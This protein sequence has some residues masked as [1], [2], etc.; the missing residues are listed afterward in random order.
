MTKPRLSLFASTLLFVISIAQVNASRA[1]ATT[2][3]G[4]R[5]IRVR[6]GQ[7][8]PKPTPTPTSKSMPTPKSKP[9]PLRLV[10]QQGQPRLSNG[11]TL[12]SPDGRLVA[13]GDGGTGDV[14]LW[15]V[16]T[17]RE[18]RRLTDNKG[19]PGAQDIDGWLWGAFSSDGHLLVTSVGPNV[20]LWNLLTG[21]RL[22]LATHGDNAFFEP[23]DGN[24]PPVAFNAQGSQIVVNG[25]EYKLT[26][27]ARTGR[28]LSRTSLGRAAKKLESFDLR[29]PRNA[30]SPGGRFVASAKDGVVTV[31]EKATRREVGSVRFVVMGPGYTSSY[32]GQ[33]WHDEL[34]ALAVSP[35]GRALVTADR[36]DLD[37]PEDP[38]NSDHVIRLWDVKTG[39]QTHLLTGMDSVPPN[40]RFTAAGGLLGVS[41]KKHEFYNAREMLSG[42]E[43]RW[44]AA[45]DTTAREEVSP[46]GRF[47]VTGAGLVG[48]VWDAQTGERLAR[49]ESKLYP[50]EKADTVGWSVARFTP[51]DTVTFFRDSAYGEPEAVTLSTLDWKETKLAFELPL[52]DDERGFVMS[53]DGRA[54][55]WETVGGGEDGSQAAQRVNVWREGRPVRSFKVDADEAYTDASHLLLSPDGRR[56]LVATSNNGGNLKQMLVKVYDVDS[57]RAV[58]TLKRPGFRVAYFAWSPDGR[59]I[60][61]SA[62]TGAG[63][64]AALWDAAT[65]AELRRLDGPEDLIEEFSPDSRLL[66]TFGGDGFERV[67]EASTGKELCRFITRA[68][69][70]WVAVDPEG[71]FDAS[72]LEEI[73]GVHWLAPE[74]PLRPLP[75]EIFM[76]DYYE[77]RLLA[78]ILSGERFAPVRSLSAVK[79]AQPSVNIISVEQDKGRPEFARVTVE[80]SRPADGSEVYDLR[81][82]REG[83]LVAYAPTAGGVLKTDA[84]T[85]K[86][87]VTFDDIRLP[88]AGVAEV[89]DEARAD[90]DSDASA[91]AG[92]VEFSAYAFNE[93]RVKSLTARTSFVPPA[94]TPQASKGRAYVISVGV[95]AYENEE[96]DLRFAANDARRLQEVVAARVRGGGEYEEVVSVP[97]ISDYASEGGRKQTPRVF[98]ET[99]ATKRNFRAVLD[100]LAGRKVDE[101]VLKGIP[102]ADRLRRATP[103]DLIIVS[104]SSHGYADERGRFFLF[105][106]DVGKSG[107]LRD[108]LGRAISSDELG[109]WL[110]DVDAGELILVVDACHSAASVQGEGFKPGPMGSRGLGQLSYDKGMRIL[111]STQASDVALESGLIEQ[112]LLTYALTRDGLEA[113][114]ADFRPKDARIT[115][116]EWL[117]YGVERVP[118]LHAEVEQ[119]LAEMKA[120]ADA[121]AASNLSGDE[122]ARVV[123]FPE[124]ERGLKVKVSGQSTRTQQPALFDFARRRRDAVLSKTQ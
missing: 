50:G 1:S 34:Y 83:R 84:Q 99:A 114:R 93:D 58:Y 85:G 16:E 24:H 106:S 100:L 77:P 119:K 80:A 62:G 38:S 76:R 82:F 12:F 63:E 20:R 4:A 23:D 53:P 68:D 87:T 10:V 15:D 39:A 54:A 17:G 124:G 8:A 78:R 44:R 108:A 72:D 91:R 51:L 95:N 122:G 55:A 65:G 3:D 116:A 52:A 43:A 89:K 111:T 75:L 18:V 36:G 66:M 35:D 48:E 42:K 117:A 25:T 96:W 104:F 98:K 41:S 121:H 103:E 40:F 92:G 27:D 56:V 112:G 81:L 21:K 94:V 115:V 7:R 60:A 28:L 120:A 90:S 45:G 73:Q 5:G 49:V 59:T 102:N 109:A 110:R 101:G 123:V 2:Q 31:A 13:T 30:T 113:A 69:G 22:W 33:P 57:G 29:P 46:D 88:R 26:W 74:D 61:T 14:V 47:V 97:L 37:D 19:D 6:A 118:T 9:L 64:R 70:S 107:E 71:R 79:R 86:A 105:T 11:F 67:Y 32:P